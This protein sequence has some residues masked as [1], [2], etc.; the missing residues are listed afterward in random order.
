MRRRH[1]S[2]E[3]GY[4]L[5]ILIVVVSIMTIA[6]AV[7]LPLWSSVMQREREEELIF[8]G[9]QYAEAIRCF[10][11]RF[12]RYPIKLEELIEVKPRCARQLYPDPM[13]EDGSWGLI[14]AGGPGTQVRPGP[15][16]DQTEGRQPQN[17]LRAQPDPTRQTPSSATS[18]DE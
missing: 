13:T 7:V 5:V 17:G 15:T 3:G 18:M 12:G 8:R 1:P 4:S 2:P 14:Y 16:P 11:R 6:V 10:Q 9:L